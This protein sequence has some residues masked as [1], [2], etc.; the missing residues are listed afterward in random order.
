MVEAIFIFCNQRRYRRDIIDGFL[1]GSNRTK[2][3]K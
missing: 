3:S 2:E 1:N